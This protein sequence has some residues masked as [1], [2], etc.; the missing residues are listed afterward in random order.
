MSRLN[1]LEET[2][3]E[4][5]PVTVYPNPDIAS[6]KVARRIA[7]VIISKQSSNENT[8]LGLATGVTPI[9]VYTELIRLHKEE[10][11]SFKNVITFNLDE[12]YPMRPTSEQSYVAFMKEHLFDHIDIDFNNVHIPDGTL[13]LDQIPTFCIEYE[14]K[15][16]E[17]GGL[18]L[19]ILGIGRTGH[20]G[21]NEPGSAPNSGTRLVTLDDLTRS[22]AARDFGGKA[23]VPTKAITMGIGTIF[24]ARQI[25]LM[26]WNRKKAPIIKKAVEGEI[27]SDVPATYLQLSN[28]VEFVLDQDAADELTRF[29][30]PWLVKD[31]VWDEQMV[32]KAVIWLARTLK[33]PILKLTEEDYNNHGMAQLA[34]EQ[35]PVYNINVHIFNVMQHTITGWPGGKPN[36][37]DSQR[38][39]RAEP[40]KKR[41][42]IFS[43]HPDDD[44]I[45]MGGTF[46]RLADHG[47]DVHVAYQTSGNTA[48]W[49]DDALRF[50]EFAI[51][52]GKKQNTDSSK[53]E[54]LYSDMRR[55]LETK[56]PNQSDTP[57]ILTVK[58]LIRKGEAM[59][60]ARF[61]GLDD[62]H[63]HFLDLPF[64]DRGKTQKNPVKEDD[65]QKTMEL[66]QQIKPHQIFA[67]GDF[68]D[69]HGTHKVCFDIIINAM[70]RLRKTEEWTKD[71]W[72]WMYRG[73]WHEFEAHEIEMAVPLSPQEVERKRYA[74]YKHQ[75]QKDRPVFPGDDSREFWV[76]AEDR[77]R[78][79]AQIYDQ[80]GLAEYEAME[81]FVRWKF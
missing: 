76:R 59:A 56:Q 3:F 54:N 14:R 79:T 47:H 22:D 25:I 55:F 18:D 50:V 15:I 42:I 74:I 68:A 17:L 35:G 48:V 62:Q 26:A 80:L 70:K 34:T 37:D 58:A 12:Y 78:E 49:D 19:Q 40:A 21:F 52:F 65:I 8:V 66:L 61:A 36:A 53:L 38:P 31:C 43:P 29:D 2:R 4:K 20:I 75:S 30:T 32:K 69:P 16:S 7:D 9:G 45:S 64:Y 5:L 67:A 28:N 46:I 51:D 10:G 24:K 23:N 6:K 1:L 39:E 11:L 27:S 13:P 44:V 71:C 33:K 72:L 63:I 57:E 60:G 77:T 81:T 73:A 41:V